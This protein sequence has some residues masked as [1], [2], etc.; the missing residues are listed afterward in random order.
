M[1]E[2]IE[3]D[4]V[5]P[6]FDVFGLRWLGTRA[7]W[8]APLWMIPLGAIF[9]L[10]VAPLA[11]TRDAWLQLL[12]YGL[13]VPVSAFL[14]NLGHLAGGMIVGAPMHAGLVTSTIPID[15]YSDEPQ[16][17]RVHVGRAIAGPLTSA[18]VGVALLVFATAARSDLI[19]V[20]GAINLG[21]GIGALFPVPGIDGAVV[22]RE[23]RRWWSA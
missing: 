23:L 7:W 12:G 1:R 18:L 4:L 16:P 3:P 21:I 11:N 9:G 20:F 10:L 2:S 19:R 14:H 13:L 17:S 15:L 8:V 6:L 22:L 5:R